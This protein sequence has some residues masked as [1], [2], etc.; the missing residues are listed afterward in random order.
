MLTVCLWYWIAQLIK[1]GVSEVTMSY[2]YLY[3]NSILFDETVYSQ[4]STKLITRKQYTSILNTHLIFWKN[5][6]FK[7]EICPQLLENQS[8]RKPEFPT[9]ENCS[10]SQS[11]TSKMGTVSMFF[12]EFCSKIVIQRFLTKKE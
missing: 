2:T 8:K 10:Y 3:C 9:L 1:R 6:A 11:W 12:Y 7:I 4:L 5:K